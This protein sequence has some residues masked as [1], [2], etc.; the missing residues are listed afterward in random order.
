MQR[1]G[2]FLGTDVWEGSVEGVRFIRQANESVSLILGWVTLL[3]L[4]RK[5]IV[6]ARL[7][8]RSGHLR[9][10]THRVSQYRHVEQKGVLPQL[11]YAVS[12]TWD[13]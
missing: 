10:L 12:S 6:R 7:D 2:I 13:A 4:C 5:C 3:K 1:L 8:P 11:N 9:L